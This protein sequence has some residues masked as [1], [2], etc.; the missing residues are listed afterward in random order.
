MKKSRRVPVRQ[1]LHQTIILGFDPFKKIFG[2]WLTVT[3][4]PSDVR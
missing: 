4:L 1:T 3:E 2:D